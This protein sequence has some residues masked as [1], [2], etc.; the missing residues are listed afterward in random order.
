MPDHAGFAAA[1]ALRERV[2]NDVLFL[3]YSSEGFSRNLP[4][5]FQGEGPPVALVAFL[6]PPTVTCDAARDALVMGIDF[7]GNLTYAGSTGVETHPVVAH[8]DVVVPP[9][10]T[11]MAGQLALSPQH[12]RV[13]VV[14]WT[15]TVVGTAG[16]KPDTDAY[17]RSPLML[18]RLS[19]TVKL[20][21]DAKLIPLP[22]IDV[23][24][25]GPI[26]DAAA[27][28]PDTLA[29]V[30]GRVVDGAVV[31]G[32]GVSGFVPAW[33]PDDTNGIWLTGDTSA[34][35][36]FTG[37]YDLAV[38]TNPAALPILLA[39]VE[40]QIVSAVGAQATIR[41]IGLTARDGEFFVNGMAVSDEGH[42]TFSFSIVPHMDAVRPGGAINYIE[43]PFAIPPQN[44]A[45]LWFSIE[46]P[47]FD[48]SAD[49]PLWKELL[50][51]LF[52]VGTAGMFLLY[53]LPFIS[54]MEDEKRNAYLM[55]V[56]GGTSGAPT[57][58]VRRVSSHSLADV[59]LRIAVDE[60]S[61]SP[62]GPYMGLT[63][64]P[65]PRPAALMGP[66]SIQAGLLSQPITY[67]VRLPLGVVP[68]DPSL[69][70]QWTVIDPATGTVQID[71]DGLAK[72]GT[73][74][75]R[76]F[77]ITPKPLGADQGKCV[78]GCRLYRASGTQTTEIFNEVIDLAVTPAPVGPAY[79]RWDY[80]VQRPWVQLDPTTDIWHYEGAP[81]AHRHSK[82]HRLL[83]GC[84]NSSKVSRYIYNVTEMAGLPFPV[85]DLDA[86][87]YELCD[88]CFYGGPAGLRSTL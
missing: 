42:A 84:T 38:A 21:L 31:A 65:Q 45:G 71:Q 74:D 66:K 43:K 36:N 12:D 49:I 55:A 86:H 70:I 3:A 75:R 52:T 58:R 73:T 50:A 77:V 81:V 57:S 5:L 13:K 62:D 59:T 46:N 24:S 33:P 88:Y 11:L 7:T 60:Y 30:P 35:E 47:Q 72:V 37:D 56:Q 48:P 25:L 79:I 1:I 34:L 6:M 85:V 8:A 69:H 41:G 54:A 87:R 76:T 63:I 68:D 14:T 27:P 17:L 78:V 83:D 18:D 67:S 53:L 2:I 22:S 15:F 10:F 9:D 20:A 80:D 51:G 39:S 23:T 40:Q 19:A 29:L 44:Y 16:F 28:P 82:I 32:L 64:R 4:I 61:I 26:V